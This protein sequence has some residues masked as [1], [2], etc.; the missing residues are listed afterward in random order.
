[1]TTGYSPRPFVMDRPEFGKGDYRYFGAPIPAVVDQLRRA[2][3]PHVAR[4]ANEWQRMLGDTER[5][6]EDWES[7]RD[8]C[9]S[10]GQTTPD[11]DSA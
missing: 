9:H 10:A 11:A 5:F 7:F 6:P 8:R 1:M 3:Y 4:I 2:V